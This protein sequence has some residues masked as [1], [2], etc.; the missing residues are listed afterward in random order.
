[1]ALALAVP[2][3]SV[4]G[5]GAHI[6]PLQF[7]DPVVGEPFYGTRTLDY[8]PAENSADPVAVHAEERFYRGLGGANPVGD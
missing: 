3:A 4:V 1:M 5:Q 2:Q 7:G 6:L 8:E